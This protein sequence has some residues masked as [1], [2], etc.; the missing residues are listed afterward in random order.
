MGSQNT[1]QSPP[2]L[3]RNSVRYPSV[4]DWCRIARELLFL[5]HTSWS[6]GSNLTTRTRP[7]PHLRRLMIDLKVFRVYSGLVGK[8]TS[9]SVPT[10]GRNKGSYC[11]TAFSKL[12]WYSGRVHVKDKDFPLLCIKYQLGASFH[13]NWVTKL[14]IQVNKVSRP[15]LVKL[16]INW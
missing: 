9:C 3:P 11:Y 15:P 10:N 14:V 8:A 4:E 13:N 2:L 1:P 6:T 5:R 12:K 16:R 7:R